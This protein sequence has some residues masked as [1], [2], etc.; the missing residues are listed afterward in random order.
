VHV[1]KF[2]KRFYL[3]VSLVTFT[4]EACKGIHTLMS[5][6][7]NLHL[8]ALVNITMKRFITVIRAV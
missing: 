7:V 5:T 8:G 4:I 2:Y 6:L 3:L 1:G